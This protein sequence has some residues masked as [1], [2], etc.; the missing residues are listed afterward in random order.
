M[1]SNIKS[2]L[3]IL[4]FNFT[5]KLEAIVHARPATQQKVVTPVKTKTLPAIPQQPKKTANI[6]AP[7]QTP[8]LAKKVT[9][10]VAPRTSP[11]INPVSSQPAQIVAPA[12]VA[13][14]PTPQTGFAS[15]PPTM[16]Q[17]GQPGSSLVPFNK[18]GSSQAMPFNNQANQINQGGVVVVPV[19]VPI[20]TDSG[21]Q[22]PQ[23]DQTSGLPAPQ[24]NQNDDNS[25]Q[26]QN[27]N[28]N[29]DAQQPSP[30]IIVL[31]QAQANQSLN[32]AISLSPQLNCPAMPANTDN[33]S[34]A[35][36][37]IT[38]KKFRDQNFN[39]DLVNTQAIADKCQEQCKTEFNGKCY[40][41]FTS[42]NNTCE[43]ATPKNQ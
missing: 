7:K 23:S 10:P 12:N 24:S 39:T 28:S 5:Y 26:N 22:A 13:P 31:Q 19:I 41:G 14:R 37:Q 6:V 36:Y 17:K 30:T 1:K 9:A 40:T 2:I 35:D 25:Q 43:C 34:D 32:K 8:Q 16:P 15:K 4:I 20:S 3:L 27:S 33:L 42:A 38:M 29:P 21:L 18:H 11:Q